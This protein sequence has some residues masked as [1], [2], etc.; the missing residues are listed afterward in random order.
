VLPPTDL[1]G[2]VVS[3]AKRSTRP[4]GKR[5]FPVI[6]SCHALNEVGSVNDYSLL[7]RAARF[8]AERHRDQRRK[9]IEE[10]PYI[11]HPFA[12]ASALCD[13]GGVTDP[14][15]LAAALLHDTIEDTATTKEELRAAFGSRIAGIVAE[16]TDDKRLSRAVR[17]RLQVDQAAHVSKDAQQLKIA[18]KL[19]NLRDVITSPP[20]DWP[21]FRKYQYFEWAKEIVD[22]V[23][24]ANPLLAAKFDAAYAER[25]KL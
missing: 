3:P 18:D 5:E 13:E 7:L 4:Q 11:N 19:C 1:M 10:S 14:E 17:K 22:Q 23:R 16:V 21:M 25:S 12:V 6:E 9:G 8:A 24:A 20:A 2:T 15:L